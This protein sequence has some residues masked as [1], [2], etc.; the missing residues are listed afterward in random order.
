MLWRLEKPLL[1]VPPCFKRIVW[2]SENVTRWFS[3]IY[4]S[5]DIYLHRSFWFTRAVVLSTQTHKQIYESSGGGGEAPGGRVVSA[6][7]LAI[8]LLDRSPGS[9]PSSLD[10]TTK[11]STS[12]SNSHSILVWTA[13]SVALALYIFVIQPIRN[14]RLRLVDSDVTNRTALLLTCTWNVIEK[15]HLWIYLFI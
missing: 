5:I 10:L 2:L 7:I 12:S 1:I 6:S 3:S 15:N 13:A 8:T 14:R 11:N 9:F 4:S